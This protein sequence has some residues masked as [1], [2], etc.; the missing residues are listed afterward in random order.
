MYEQ[1][2][3]KQLESAGLTINDDQADPRFNL[4]VK[5]ERFY[6]QAALKG[7]L[8]FGESYADAAWDCAQLDQVVYRILRS[9]IRNRSFFHLSLYLRSLLCNMQNRLRASRVAKKHYNVDSRVFEWMLDPYMQYTCGYWADADSL[10]QAQAAK[11]EL[12]IRKLGLKAGDEV[13]DIGCGWGGFARYA[14]ENHGIRMHGVSISRSQ[15]A[16]AQN[17]CA[18]LEC[19]IRYGDYRQLGELFPQKFDAIS[20]IGVTEHI[21]HKNLRALHRIMRDRLKSGGLVMEHTIAHM[22]SSTYTEPFIDK[23]IFPGGMIPSI[24]QLSEAMNR[25]FVL[26]DLHNFSADYDHTLMAWHLNFSRA[27]ERIEQAAHLGRRFY[28]IWEYYLLSCAAMFRARRAQ[29]LQMVLSP[30]GVSGGY[31]RVS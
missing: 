11:M 12:I 28:R 6:R 19:D 17:F 9:D 15:V 25:Y 16:Y 18:G 5:D 24:S 14:A 23:Y 10:E 27:R 8:G 1:W 13:L 3:R 30:E 31:R 20:I 22:E 29:L 4:R 26:E 7:S 21:G 2:V